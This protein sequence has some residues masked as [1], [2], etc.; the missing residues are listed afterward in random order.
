MSLYPWTKQPENA[1]LQVQVWW[2][3]DPP[4][5]D[6]T[7]RGRGPPIGRKFDGPYGISIM[8]MIVASWSYETPANTR[9]CVSFSAV[10]IIRQY[11]YISPFLFPCWVTTPPARSTHVKR[12]VTDFFSLSILFFFYSFIFLISFFLILFFCISFFL[13]FFLLFGTYVSFFFPIFISFLLH[14]C[15][16]SSIYFS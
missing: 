2:R 10:R 1:P 9:E 14:V 11:F 6:R 12:C 7:E 16:F 13:F 15:L 5:R 3:K 8:K 4:P